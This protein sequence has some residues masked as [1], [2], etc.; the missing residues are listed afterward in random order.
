MNAPTAEDPGVR[1]KPVD[2][3]RVVSGGGMHD[4]PGLAPVQA[5]GPA[6]VCYGL[7]YLRTAG[8]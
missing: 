8:S 7:D 4:H 3:R 6:C 5:D 2:T 1:T